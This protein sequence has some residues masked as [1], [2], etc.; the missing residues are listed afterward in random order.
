MVA[1]LS[2]NTRGWED[3]VDVFSDL[4]RDLNKVREELLHL[5]D[6]DSNAFNAIMNAFKFPKNNEKEKQIRKEEI[7][8]A[9]LYAAEVPL[10]VMRKAFQCYIYITKLS[11]EGNQ[12]SLSDSGVA[13]LCIYACIYGAYLNVRIN[14]KGIENDNGIMNEAKEIIAKSEIEKEKILSFIQQKI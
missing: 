7:N 8:K 4:A 9:T 13:C 12:N 5:V 2:C 11:K 10:R 1:N 14:L 6:E 3:K